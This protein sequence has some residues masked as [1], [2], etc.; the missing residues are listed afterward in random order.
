[1]V[2]SKIEEGLIHKNLIL[3][4][5]V[6]KVSSF[7]KKLAYMD[8]SNS[9]KIPNTNQKRIVIIGGGVCRYNHG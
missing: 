7:I 9:F 1:M 6:N 5:A 3:L 8:K 4:E 2:N